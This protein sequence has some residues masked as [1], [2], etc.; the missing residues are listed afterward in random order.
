[1]Y[2]IFLYVHVY[3][4]YIKYDWEYNDKYMYNQRVVLQLTK[5]NLRLGKSVC[6]GAFTWLNMKS[7]LQSCELK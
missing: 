7:I 2:I 5:P 4:I 6:C 1:M 3:Y